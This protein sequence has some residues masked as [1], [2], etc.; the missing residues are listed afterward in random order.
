MDNKQCLTG[1]HSNHFDFP[2]VCRAVKLSLHGALPRDVTGVIRKHGEGNVA[3][4]AEA[5]AEASWLVR[6]AHRVSTE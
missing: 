2:V 6:S 1:S 4:E 5:E 3:S